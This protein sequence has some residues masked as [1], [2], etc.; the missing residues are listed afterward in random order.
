[1]SEDAAAPRGRRVTVVLAALVLLAGAV[2]VAL[3]VSRSERPGT[4]GP[5]AGFARDMS[6]HH[7]QAVR[8]SFI[9]RDRT[10]DPD[11]RLLAYDIINTQSAQIGMM[12]AWLDE[13]RLPK[14]DPAGPMRWMSGH[15]GHGEGGTATMPG[16]ATR[17]QLAE[18]EKASGRTAEVLFLRLMIAHHRG[19]V[20]MAEAVLART[21]HDRVRRLARTMVEGQQAE[22]TQMNAM[23]R[24]R[25]GPAA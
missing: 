17:E 14:A 3:A 21:G 24:R 6:A 1:M 12:T 4:D 18:L 8:M 23:L 11:V 20:G 16:M 19:G 13:W 15:G 7:A 5:E 25:G 2:L 22:I 10:D 9:V